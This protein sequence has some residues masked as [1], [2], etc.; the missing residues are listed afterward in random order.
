VRTCVDTAKT[1][2]SI[3]G[4]YKLLLDLQRFKFEVAMLFTI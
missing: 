1:V 4:I 3:P 2:Y